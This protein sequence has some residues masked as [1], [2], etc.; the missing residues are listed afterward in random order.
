MSWQGEQM[1]HPAGVEVAVGA[2]LGRV[3]VWPTID[4]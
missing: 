2:G 3:Q 4:V 1:R